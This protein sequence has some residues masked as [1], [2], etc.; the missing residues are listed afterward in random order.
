MGEQLVMRGTLE[1]HSGWVTSLATTLEKSVNLF[2]QHGIQA[3]TVIV[4]QI[5]FSPAAAT[6]P[7]LSGTSLETIRI[8]ATQNGVCMATLTLCRT[9]YVFSKGGAKATAGLTKIITGDF[10]GR[11]LCA[12]GFL[13]QDSS[14][15]GVSHWCDDPSLCWP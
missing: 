1:G 13:G 10:F 5:C 8:T 6:K 9:A 7:S 14:P 12:L 3:L 11:S 15:L 4:A 2:D